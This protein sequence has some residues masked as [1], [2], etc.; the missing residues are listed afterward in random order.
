MSKR[1]WYW[2]LSILLLPALIAIGAGG[3]LYWLGKRAEPSYS[4]T[5]ALSG[6]ARPV[7][8]RFG[9]HAVPTIEASDLRDLVFAQGYV[10]A[11]ERM[12]QM[13]LLRRL[14]GGR[15]AELFGPEVV[16]VDRF[17]RTVGLP[18]E[19]RRALKSMD[20]ADRAL[21]DAYAA[22]VN[23][24]R[25]SARGRRPLEYL[26]SGLEPA[27][28]R[29]EDSLVI[30][31][32][33]AWTQ[34]FNARGELTFLRLARRIG[35]ER[36]R[37][38]FPTDEGI[39]P[40][41]VPPE[42]LDYL[43]TTSPVAA[44]PAS[45]FD[46]ATLAP[47]LDYPA[48]LGL[49][50]PTPASNAWLATG[51]R[52]AT[53]EALL[54]ND[55]HL[56]FSMPGIWYELEL[57]APELHVAGVSLPGVP[58]VLIGHNADL[59]WG[60]TSVI[61]DTQDIF[62]ERPTADGLAVEREGRAPEPIQIRHETIDVRGGAA[63][64]IAI[65]STSRGVILNDILGE[66]TGTLMDLSETGLDSELI[67][68]RQ[69]HDAP[70]R[71]FQAVR[72]LCQARTL[73][74][75]RA[76]GLNFRHVATNLMLAHRDG[77]IAWQMTGVLPQ[78]GR[79]SGVFPV[80]GWLDAY[81]WQG[82][83]PQ[84][85]NPSTIN[86][87]DGLIITA[88][89]R[90]IPV[91]YPVQVSNAWMSPHR[92]QRIAARLSASGPL[93]PASMA[94][95][96]SDRVSLQGRMM[97]TSLRRLESELRA[98]DPDAWSIAETQLL[99]WD[100]AMDGASR[101]AAFAALLEPALFQAL[102]GD[103][104]GADLSSLLSLSIVAY[105]PLQETLRTGESEFWDDVTTPEI[106]TP[107]T[108]WARALRSA[109]TAL[110][111]HGDDVRLDQIRSVRFTHAFDRLPLLGDL[112]SVGPTGVGGG[113]DTVDVIKT[114]PQEPG[115]G[116][117][118]AST[119][120]VATPADWHQTRGTLTLGQSGHRFSPY[121]TD[122]LDDWLAVQSHIWPWHGPDEVRTIG[123]L[124]LDPIDGPLAQPLSA[125]AARQP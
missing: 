95:I 53:G 59:A 84:S 13:D 66:I 121:R 28:W 60:V 24:Y 74:E 63:V 22:G 72:G 75:A 79:S 70:D 114:R 9:P 1:R 117:F 98:L 122:Q 119:R 55:P 65:R 47:I 7:A 71:A 76:A 20:D 17:F 46:I 39:A 67:A 111:A 68:L 4:G 36:A 25:D 2:L 93:T 41:E 33:M 83:V 94:E 18:V 38:L 10:T 105:N 21:L 108:I 109:R 12:W 6:L 49:P 40:P 69:T 107:A 42:L 37:M 82:E 34:S 50:T 35:P 115:K 123:H 8:V 77:G 89:Q 31:T 88:N 90:T 15:L 96:Q 80:P 52:T 30:G 87:T 118:G 23:A 64:D 57:I 110:D 78:R 81:D 101:P 58:L 14:G 91:D 27:P 97:L 112:F 51:A 85:L 56:A 103:E 29:P 48:R 54:A 125:P 99:D 102:Y 44:S 43:A 61:A 104:L 106:E 92:A 26:I 86:P 32:Y 100:G 73:D 124:R 113:S 11:S 62:I 16:A 19:A 5:V 3:T 116:L 45:G 120:F